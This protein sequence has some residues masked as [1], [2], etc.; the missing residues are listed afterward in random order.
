MLNYMYN[1]KVWRYVSFIYNENGIFLR[2]NKRGNRCNFCS[3]GLFLHFASTC[4]C[5]KVSIK[6]KLKET[7]IIW[8][9]VTNSILFLQLSSEFQ[10]RHKNLPKKK[11]KLSE[12]DVIEVVETVCSSGFEKSVMY[13]NLF[14]F[15]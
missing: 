14:I 6:R 15:Y 2:F 1:I 5:F 10:R 7:D 8:F 11:K 3:I 12:S 13:I 9:C 4:I